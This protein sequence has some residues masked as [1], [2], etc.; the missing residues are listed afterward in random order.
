MADFLVLANSIK[1]EG[2]C[3][4]GIL[5]PYS[6]DLSVCRLVS[7]KDGG[8]ICNTLP[9]QNKGYLSMIKPLDVINVTLGQSVPLDGQPENILLDSTKPVIYKNTMKKDDL[10]PFIQ[11]PDCIWG[12][13]SVAETFHIG[14][15]I[16]LIEVQNPKT[17]KTYKDLPSLNFV[18]NRINYNIRCTEE[19]FGYKKIPNN[20]NK[21]IICVSSGTNFNGSFYKFVASVIF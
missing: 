16:K 15:S 18:F 4:A 14:D 2:R 10:T 17:D 12:L 8:S 7:D 19:N 3:L 9:I 20:I 1:N 6:S 11:H 13:D 5:N 21:C